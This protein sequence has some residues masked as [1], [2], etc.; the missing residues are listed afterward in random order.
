MAMFLEN[1]QHLPEQEESSL[2]D[3]YRA[4]RR[5]FLFY[6]VTV[7]ETLNTRR[8]RLWCGRSD[9]QWLFDE[10]MEEVGSYSEGVGT[11]EKGFLS[12]YESHGLTDL[13]FVVDLKYDLL[14]IF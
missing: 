14:S 6:R 1:S 8:L 7:R 2:I 11:A 12:A 13:Y 5:G 4:V 3:L 10:E 9:E